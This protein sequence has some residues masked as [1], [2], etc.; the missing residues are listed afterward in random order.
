MFKIFRVLQLCIF[1][2]FPCSLCSCDWLTSSNT[3]N[4]SP[5]PVWVSSLS[6]GESIRGLFPPIMTEKSVITL[7][8]QNKISVLYNIEKLS[9][10]KQWEWKDFSARGNIIIKRIH[11]YQNILVILDRRKLYAINTDTGKTIWISEVSDYTV[12]WI[13]GSG[14]YFFYGLKNA[15]LIGNTASGQQ[16]NVSFNL[17]NVLFIPPVSYIQPETRDTLL[18]AT[19]TNL[20]KDSLGRDFYKTYIVAYNRSKNKLLYQLIAQEGNSSPDLGFPTAGLSVILGNRVY[21]DVG[22]SIQ[23]NDILTGNLIWR[24]KFLGSF[25]FSSIIAADGKIFGNSDDEGI[26]YALNPDTGDIIWQEPTSSASGDMHYMNGVI[27]IVGLGDGKLHALDANT[28]KHIWRLTAPDSESSK[29]QS[30]FEDAVTGD[31]QY[32]YVR[33]FLNLYCYKAAR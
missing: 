27:Y 16:E 32:I 26:M 8:T 15:F 24:R 20:I 4:N 18:L 31:G 28:G 21:T 9:G 25:Y 19:G 5:E 23:C 12:P 10:K 7:G 1:V 14:Q 2:V 17:D 30:S 33:S 29:G 22:R 6:T 11:Q 13:S 3:T